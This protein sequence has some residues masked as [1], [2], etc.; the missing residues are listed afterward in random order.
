MKEMFWINSRPTTLSTAPPINGTLNSTVFFA[1]QLAAVGRGRQQG[2]T[3][4]GSRRSMGHDADLPAQPA[5]AD[6]TLPFALHD[7]PLAGKN[8]VTGSGSP[9]ERTSLTTTTATV[10]SESTVNVSKSPRPPKDANR[11]S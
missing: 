11:T 1:F 3:G 6:R 5:I 4:S 7:P 8:L 9:S 10:P 2:R